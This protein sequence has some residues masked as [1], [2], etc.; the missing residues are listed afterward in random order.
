V[1]GGTAHCKGGQ[2]G[3]REEHQVGNGCALT[4]NPYDPTLQTPAITLKVDSSDQGKST[5]VAMI[6]VA[7]DK[8]GKN[9]I[10]CRGANE[11]CGLDEA[12]LADNLMRKQKEIGIVLMQNEVAHGARCL[13]FCLKICA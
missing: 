1:Y 2:L 3:S 7:A 8:S 12:M 9:T 6:I 10:A 4:I 11:D 13:L 5:G